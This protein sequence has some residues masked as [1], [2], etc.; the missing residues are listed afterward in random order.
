MKRLAI[1]FA[2]L[3]AAS[4]TVPDAAFAKG[5]RGMGHGHAFKVSHGRS[6]LGTPPGWH[7]G[8]KVGWGN[9]GCPPGLWKQGRC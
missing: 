5:S 8:R 1:S 6:S 7:H 3:L 9:M 2:L 4:V